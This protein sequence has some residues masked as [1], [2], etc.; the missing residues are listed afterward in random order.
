MGGGRRSGQAKSGLDLEGEE[1]GGGVH[2]NAEGLAGFVGL[3]FKSGQLGIVVERIVM[4]EKEAGDLGRV[5]FSQ[6][7]FP[8]GMTPANVIVAPLSDIFIRRILRIMDQDI[9]LGGKTLDRGTDLTAVFGV[10]A[11]G[12]NGGGLVG[13]MFFHAVAEASA[14]VVEGCPINVKRGLAPVDFQRLRGQVGKGQFGRHVFK[15]NRKA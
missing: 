11:K 13:A 6:G 8:S 7:L 15:I 3:F 10:G 5:S 14:G 2:V 1:L 9:S 4:G 12:E